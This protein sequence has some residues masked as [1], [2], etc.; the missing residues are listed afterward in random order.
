MILIDIKNRLF[1]LFA[2]VVNIF[3]FNSK[4]LSIR[5]S[6]NG[7]TCIYYIDFGKD[8]FY[9]VINDLK[10]YF[11]E[12][13]DNKYLTMIFTSKTQ[14]MMYTRIWEEIKKV[15][16]EVDEISNYDKNYDVIS[17]DTDDILSLNS[18]INIRSLTIIIK[19]VFKD[20]NKFYPQIY[21]TDYRY[22]KV[23]S[24]GLVNC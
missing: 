19:S 7:E 16:N 3:E 22:N 14:K 4:R 13:D 9:F 24:K 21:L 1:T 8:P 2:K 11:E 15:I 23:L 17:F 18:I 12:N 10:G 20:N 6:G 5:K